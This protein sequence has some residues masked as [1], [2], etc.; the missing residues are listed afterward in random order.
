MKTTI[1]FDPITDR[2][3]DIDAL[4]YTE[5]DKLLQYV[6][7]RQLDI[8]NSIQQDNSDEP[9]MEYDESDKD[10]QYSLNVS[11]SQNTTTTK[12]KKIDEDG[13]ITP[14]KTTKAINKNNNGEIKLV[15]KFNAIQNNENDNDEH[16]NDEQ[17]K[18]A[19]LAIEIERKYRSI[20][21][22]RKFCGLDIV[23]EPMKPKLD[24]IQCYRCQLY[25]HVQKNDN[26]APKCMICVLDHYTYECKKERT[27]PATCINCGGDHT[28]ASKYCSVRPRPKTWKQITP[29]STKS[30]REI[31]KEQKKTNKKSQRERNESETET[32]KKKK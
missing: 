21:N 25:R 28:A 5:L 1:K 6:A 29:P 15:N 30:I 24:V 32:D 22:I 8:E 23:I 4:P 9:E 27:T 11:T 10:S 2:A 13:F 7:A 16:D 3:P 14:Q 19:H 12:R 26:A 17:R 20:Y 31:Q 18:S